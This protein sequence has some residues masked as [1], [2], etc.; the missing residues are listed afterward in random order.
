MGEDG[1][2]Y[3]SDD[4]DYPGKHEELPD[5][6]PTDEDLEKFISP[7]EM[8]KMRDI[9]NRVLRDFGGFDAPGHINRGQFGFRFKD[10][11]NNPDH[12]Q[13]EDDEE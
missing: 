4:D 13:D 5:G 3:F 2:L 8:K 12:M 1:M 11:S 7:D 6:G 10:W 9:E